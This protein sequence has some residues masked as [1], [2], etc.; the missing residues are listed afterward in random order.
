MEWLKEL[1]ENA[2]LD[3]EEQVGAIVE[4]YKKEAPKHTVPKDVYNS[5]TE[6]AKAAEAS[7]SERDAQLTELQKKAGE[8]SELQ[9]E[10]ERLQEENEK[11]KE[12]YETEIYQ[13][14]FDSA[15]QQRLTAAKARD[16]KI[17]RAAFDLQDVTLDEDGKLVGFDEQLKNVQET[18]GY[19]F[20]GE[21]AS[22]EGT[23]GSMGNS[24]RGRKPKEDPFLKGL[25][26]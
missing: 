4:S 25:G 26:L 2:G 22:P 10:I 6:R 15:I 7:L 24:G 19:L 9:K 17:A 11:A 13:T 5:A 8:D 23:G 1:L 18:H 12:Q 20:A 14:K 16:L 21:E 3:N